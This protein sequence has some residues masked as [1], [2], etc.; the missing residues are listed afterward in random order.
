MNVKHK[1]FY[2]TWQKASKAAIHLGLLTQ[3]MYD[4]GHHKDPKLPGSLQRTYKD[5]PGWRKFRGYSTKTYARINNG[6]GRQKKKIYS[7]WQKAAKA[8]KALEIDTRCEYI[9]F[10]KHNPFLHS[11]PQVIYPDFPGWKKFLE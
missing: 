6:C 4:K 3:S 5:F 10:Y 8:A 7:T 1:V 2:A 11:T 9:L